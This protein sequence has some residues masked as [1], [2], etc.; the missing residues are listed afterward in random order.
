MACGIGT[1]YNNDTSMCEDCP[2]GEYQDKEE[3]YY[4]EKCTGQK[5]TLTVGSTNVSQCVGKYMGLGSVYI[6]F[7][8]GN[9]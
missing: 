7:P 4:C 3:Q 5:T 9:F 6:H 1:Y 8:N 2:L